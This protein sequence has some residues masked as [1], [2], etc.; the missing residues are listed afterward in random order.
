MCCIS[1][2]FVYMG[3]LWVVVVPCVDDMP[4]AP[5]KL[6]SIWHHKTQ[7]QKY[8]CYVRANKVSWYKLVT[9]PQVPSPPHDRVDIGHRSHPVILA[10]LGIEEEEEE[11]GK[12]IVIWSNQIRKIGRCVVFHSRPLILPNTY[13]FNLILLLLHLYSNTTNLHLF[14]P[15]LF[16]CAPIFLHTFLV[17]HPCHQPN[18]LLS[19]L[20]P[21]LS[22]YSNLGFQSR[23]AAAYM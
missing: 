10:S 9:W 1:K 23:H 12:K 22:I 2:P 8:Y 17:G 14:H 19:F 15:F 3:K 13:V 5:E 16:I 7:H 4:F 18:P 6:R 20:D 21:W 11:E